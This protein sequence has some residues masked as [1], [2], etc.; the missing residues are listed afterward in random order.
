MDGQRALVYARSRMSTSDFDRA[1]R[2]QEVLVA[3]RQK[4]LSPGS[5]PRLPLLALIVLDSLETD[6]SPREIMALGLLAVRLDP[7]RLQRVVLEPP[8]VVGQRRADG[9]AIQLPNW[10]LI[11]PHL[12]EHFR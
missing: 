6:L 8:L 7:S 10:E 9:A 12:D 2:Q 5:L 3:I 11:N 1:R 4:A